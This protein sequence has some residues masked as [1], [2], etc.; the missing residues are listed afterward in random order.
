MTEGEYIEFIRQ[1]R[2][3]EIIAW[4]GPGEPMIDKDIIDWKI[5][6]YGYC[7]P[8]DLKFH[9]TLEFC[10]YKYPVKLESKFEILKEN[11]LSENSISSAFKRKMINEIDEVLSRYKA[12]SIYN[13]HES[14]SAGTSSRNYFIKYYSEHMDEEIIHKNTIPEDTIIPKAKIKEADFYQSLQVFYHVVTTRLQNLKES[15]LRLEDS[16]GPL[17]NRG[18]QLIN[19]EKYHRNLT[20]ACKDLKEKG[21]IHESTN[22]ADFKRIFNDVEIVNRINWIGGIKTLKYFI[23]RAVKVDRIK[24]KPRKRF[25]TVRCCFELDGDLIPD[26]KTWD[27]KDPALKK[28]QELNSIVDFLHDEY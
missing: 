5:E 23:N 11:I 8:G 14:Y 4:M 26:G 21:Y 24:D 7:D 22:S 18:F 19:H 28:Q 10:G 25:E 16:A 1:F 20:S 13:K 12:T 2:K 9:S 27:L 6:K 15:I 3:P 17:I